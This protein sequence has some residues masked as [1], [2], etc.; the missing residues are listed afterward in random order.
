MSD[1]VVVSDL[2]IEVV[3]TITSIELVNPNSSELTS[4][5]IR[6]KGEVILK[7]DNGA[8]YNRMIA[9][10]IRNNSK[11]SYDVLGETAQSLYKKD[12]N[13]LTVLEVRHVQA[14][15][16]ANNIVSGLNAENT[17]ITID[18]VDGLVDTILTAMG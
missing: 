10:A 16:V 3:Q 11:M 17:G 9:S 6:W 5:G 14:V 1:I 15:L 12:Y 18:D 7:G 2:D 4:D 13:D 8:I